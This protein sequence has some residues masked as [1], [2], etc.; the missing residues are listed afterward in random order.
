MNTF[1]TALHSLGACSDGVRWASKQPDPITAWAT[2]ERADWMLWILGR[3]AGP[4]D[5]YSRMRLVCCAAECAETS[6]QFIH[7]KGVRD[8]V[9]YGLVL[10]RLY[11]RGQGDLREARRVLNDAASAYAAAYAAAS[12]A[13]DAA[14]ADA[15]AASAAAADADAAS[16][17]ASAAASAA[18]SADAASA[19]A[20]ADAARSKALM[21]MARIVR[22]HY[23][24]PPQ[25]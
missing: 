11:L 19:Y 6:L 16:A 4:P 14:A 23:P 10:L 18:A 1:S 13:A 7:D 2:C 15:D 25:L 12:A 24:T 20:A 5:S 8:Q 22:R 17:D 9:K 3:L 21:E